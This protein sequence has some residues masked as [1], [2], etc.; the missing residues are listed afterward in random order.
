[1]LSTA[2]TLL[3]TAARFVA[4]HAIYTVYKHLP[5]TQARFSTVSKYLNQTEAIIIDEELFNEYHFKVE[6]LMELAGLR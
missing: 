3:S 5:L 2:S 6:Q 1:M 4:H